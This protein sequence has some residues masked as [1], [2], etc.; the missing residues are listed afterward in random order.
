VFDDGLGSLLVLAANARWLLPVGVSCVLVEAVS[1][2]VKYEQPEHLAV[3]CQCVLFTC[4]PVLKTVY[5]AP[6]YRFGAT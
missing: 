4:V 6:L 5:W 2:P 3:N 1:P